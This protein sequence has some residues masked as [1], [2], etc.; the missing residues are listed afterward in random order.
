MS[1]LSKKQRVAIVGGGEPVGLNIAKLLEENGMVTEPI[2]K[3]E[4]HP[5]GMFD[6]PDAEE[7]FEKQRG[8]QIASLR[9]PGK[10][11][12]GVKLITEWIKHRREVK[13]K[14]LEIEKEYKYH[15]MVWFG[16]V[17]D[18]PFQTYMERAYREI[19]EN[20]TKEDA[21]LWASEASDETC[22]YNPLPI[23]SWD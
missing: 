7:F 16:R 6:H 1:G 15:Q 22:Y 3:M 18:I 2:E 12:L 5:F 11:Q 19:N 20:A 13:K 17:V 4:R 23:S 8:I 10:S 14:A 9:S 21:E